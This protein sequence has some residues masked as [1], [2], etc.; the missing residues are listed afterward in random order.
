MAIKRERERESTFHACDDVTVPMRA[1]TPPT[2]GRV[3]FD[4][5]ISERSTWIVTRREN[6]TA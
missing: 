5:E 6:D 4:S 1:I 3:E 2:I